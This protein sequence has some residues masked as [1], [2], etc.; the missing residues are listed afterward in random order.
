MLPESTRALIRRA[1]S[2]RRAGRAEQHG[3][4]LGESLLAVGIATGHDLAEE[5][6]I[7]AAA[8]EV[9]APPQHQR[10]VDGLL[11]PVMALL[12]VA[13][14]VRLARL[15]RLGFEAVVRH[16]GLVSPSEHLG[17]WI[18]VDRRGQAIGAVPSRNSSQFPQGVLQPFA[19]A[20]EALG[21]ADRAGL[22][23]GIRQHE[24][25]DQVIE[26]FAG[27]GDAEGRPCG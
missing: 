4:F 14:L 5:R 1:I 7:L 20:L 12:D 9:A 25:V 19:E 13:V 17:L 6:L 11:E 24:V 3:Q 22:P 15:D 2:S 16:Q 27:D 26:R 8:D 21:E 18:G 10:L 23:V